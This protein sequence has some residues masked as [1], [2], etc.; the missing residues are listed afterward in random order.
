MIHRCPECG[1]TFGNARGLRTHY[2]QMHRESRLFEVDPDERPMFS[3]TVHLNK[4]QK[5][6]IDSN[7]II[8]SEWVRM[9]ID[10]EMKQQRLEAL[11]DV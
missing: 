2:S 3:K 5:R 6:W 7:A 4:R 9:R 1:R 8:L 11:S 10:E